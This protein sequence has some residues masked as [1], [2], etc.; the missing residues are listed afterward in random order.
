MAVQHVHA[1][2]CVGTGVILMGSIAM[3]A[4]LGPL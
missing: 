3:K 2:I 1:N 4:R